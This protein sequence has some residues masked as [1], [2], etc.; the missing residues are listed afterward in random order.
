LFKRL[1]KEKKKQQVVVVVRRQQWR[2]N[3]WMQKHPMM[4]MG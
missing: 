1:K 2:E 4:T 3:T